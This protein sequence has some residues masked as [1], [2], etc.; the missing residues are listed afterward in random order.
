MAE[1]WRRV[2]LIVNPVAGAD[3]KQSLRAAREMI[4]R[5]GAE[6]VLTGPDELG[7]AAL[8]GWQGRV[9]ICALENDDARPPLGNAQTRALA[10]AL[11]HENLDVLVVVGG[12]GTLAD[13]A[14]VCI[15]TSSQVPIV[16]IGCGST[17]AGRLVTLPMHRAREF[18]ATKVE[19]WSPDCLLATVNGSQ[20]GLAFNDIVIGYTVV[21]TI[22]GRRQDLD[23]FDRM[24]GNITP[25]KPRPAGNPETKVTRIDSGLET[26]I[27]EGQSVGTVVF[28][29]AEPRFI[30]KAITGA[31]CLAAL[32]GLP[33]GCLVCEKP[34][35]MVD[36]TSGALRTAP[37][38]ASRFVAFDEAMEVKVEGIEGAVLCADGNPLHQLHDA[39]Q[40]AVSV[41]RNAVTA[42]RTRDVRSG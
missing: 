39:D 33:A 5:S 9:Q 1:S 40:V 11:V 19:T 23:A 7:A 21:G 3:K 38:M 24:H 30:G 25:G 22:E 15:H 4:E 18:D 36:I 12:D 35:A 16:G 6:T 2:G 27:A 31:V 14:Q 26:V 34:L 42:V 29:F 13:V 37:P 28:G 17:N 41:R 20:V 10:R 32:S 8:T